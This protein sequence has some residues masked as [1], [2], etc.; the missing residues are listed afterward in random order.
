MPSSRITRSS[1]N[2]NQSNPPSLSNARHVEC[3]VPSCSHNL[4]LG[5][6]QTIQRHLRDRHTSMELQ[7]IPTS[8]FASANV[9][10]C[11]IC[12]TESLSLHKTPQSLSRHLSNKHEAST[13]N[14]LNSDLILSRL[15]PPAIHEEEVKQNWIKT[16]RYLHSTDIT[17]F[18]FRKS[19]YH[20]LDNHTKREIQN[21][22]NLVYIVTNTANLPHVNTRQ[23]FIPSH[24]LSASPLWKL[25]ILFEG[26]LMAP[27]S[28]LESRNYQKLI[29]QRLTLFHHGRF[30]EL[31]RTAMLY[32][33]TPN[34]N[35]PTDS[36]RAHQIVQAANIDDW[37]RASN[38]LKEPAPAMPYTTANL[39]KVQSLHPPQTS[40]R[41]QL[42]I[43]RPT[44][45]FHKDIYA[46]STDIFQKRLTDPTLILQSLR[47]L[48]KGT[49]AGPF[50]DSIDFLQDVF[51]RRSKT[52]NEEEKLDNIQT[53]CSLYANIFTGNVPKDIKKYLAYN[54]SVSFYKN[55]PSTENV[56]PIGIGVAWG[57]LS[58]AHAVNMTKD[59]A[60]QF[61]APSQFAIG[62]SAGMDFV[63]HM[64]QSQVERY[65]AKDPSSTT[66]PS[67]ALLILDL[68]NMFNNVSMV[69]ARDII[70]TKF[71]HLLPLFDMLYYD[72]TRCYYRDTTG[73]R[74][75]FLRHEGS[76]QGCPFAALLACLILHDILE[77]IE[78][79]LQQRAN[80]RKNSH[81]NSDDSFGSRAITMCY[82]DDTTISIHYD[83]IRFFFDA[84]EAAG[85]PLGCFLKPQKCKILT[86]TNKHSPTRLLSPQ[87]KTDL[88]YALDKYCG[89]ATTGEITDGT[90]ILGHP[91]GHRDFVQT[92]QNKTVQKIRATVTS[93][94]TLVK[95]PQVSMSIYKY[96]LQHYAKHLLFTDVLHSPTTSHTY[97]HHQTTFTS[98]IDSLTKTYLAKLL[99]DPD[100]TS[101][102]LPEHAWCIASTP[103]GL[104]GLGF[105]DMSTISI[106]SFVMPFAKTIRAAQHGLA[107]TPITSPNVEQ[108]NHSIT[109]PKHIS[110]SLRS[111]K[112]SSLPVFQTYTSL[113]RQYITGVDFKA[114]RE[115]GDR[116]TDFTL[117]TPL[118]SNS[119]RFQKDLLTKRAQLLWHRLTPSL[120]K[121]FPSTMSLLTS[122]PMNNITRTDVTNRF[123]PPEFCTYAQR[124]LRLPLWPPLP[125]TCSCNAPIDPYGD[126][127]F[128]C[129]K[130]SKTHLHNRIRDSLYLICQQISPL[131][132]SAS[133]KDVHLEMPH[134]FTSAPRKRPGDVV[135]CHPIHGND[136]HH[137]KTLIDVTIIPPC[138]DISDDSTFP[139]IIQCMS[140]H[141]QNHELKKFKMTTHGSTLANTMAQEATTNRYRLL[142]FTVDHQGMVGPVASDF[143]FSELTTMF[144]TTLLEYDT[145][146]SSP[147]IN[148]MV[149]LAFHKK[150]Q[151]NILKLATR[152]WIRQYGTKWFT[153]TYQAQNPAQWAKQVLGTTFS[154]HS[155]R[156]ILQAINT[157]TRPTN[158]SQKSHRLQCCSMNLHTPT[159][160]A[161]RTLQ[162]TLN[163]IF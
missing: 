60:A 58:A 62:L 98:T 69:R 135:M 141:H 31:H 90:R 109:L 74:N 36:Q 156:H 136:S 64:T 160:Y 44:Q 15:P 45:S 77:P 97:K 35:K 41:S 155:A 125:H 9:H 124:K 2:R 29:R 61:L 113:M 150:R 18:A 105:I 91:I 17:P 26:T 14:A 111:W 86:S 65:I 51:L 104:G 100:S 49:A 129:P 40:F 20:L 144:K 128:T 52:P 147:P 16:L 37:R 101:T 140:K 118:H 82:I 163:D 32:R 12:P 38:L 24:E 131:I 63:T 30:D 46:S 137:S 80:Q 76:S 151:R 103:T 158:N 13:R 95:D 88:I 110:Y 4:R 112:T 50:A 145:R 73:D 153:N 66:P 119:L 67:R 139:E 28:Q 78:K 84:F 99:G 120:K 123:T 106:K 146:I 19:I 85:P 21:L 23:R 57:R 39:P 132:S 70:Y 33:A 11:P 3:P 107:P 133:S 96:S 79:Q 7:C 93:L 121:S 138:K 53:L 122:I 6:A 81:Q 161:Q 89:G 162:Y 94:N 159:Q 87:H 48:N 92:Y 157:V 152:N 56:R 75:F 22:A 127:F 1:Q 154:L 34:Y 130:A 114:S 142:P 102:S 27:P 72:E 83:D 116:L 5:Q 108:L 115:T 47:K 117:H 71:P 148:R 143:L 25:T 68:V 55:P 42:N 10:K 126:H 59:A 149:S 8:F 54:E 134:L 43:P